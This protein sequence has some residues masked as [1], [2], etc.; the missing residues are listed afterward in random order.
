M[1]PGANHRAGRARRGRGECGHARGLRGAG[2]RVA[3]DRGG[4]RDGRAV[5]RDGGAR[6]GAAVG[7]WLR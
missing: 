7:R 1:A 6:R 2:A 4:A 3:S 5:A